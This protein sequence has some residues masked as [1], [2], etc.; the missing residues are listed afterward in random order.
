MNRPL[1]I[2]LIVFLVF[3]T[4]F[5][6]L[7]F[8]LLGTE[9][10]SRW[11]VQQ[12][13]TENTDQAQVVLKVGEV[14][15]TFL[16]QLQLH[17]VQANSAEGQFLAEQIQ[18]VW[19]ASALLRGKL[20]LQ[21]LHIA[22]AEAQ[23]V[24]VESENLEESAKESE[25]ESS[26][27]SSELA[28]PFRVQ[29][30]ELQVER[31]QWRTVTASQPP[32]TIHIEQLKTT[33]QLEPDQ[34]SIR[35][36]MIQSDVVDLRGDATLQPQAPYPFSAELAW[37]KLDGKLFDLPEIQ[38][39]KGQLQASGTTEQYDLQVRGTILENKSS[40]IP[41]TDVQFV[42]I[43]H[44]D[45]MKFELLE[46]QTLSGKIGAVGSMN[47]ATDFS[48]DFAVTAENVDPG[49][50]DSAWAAALGGAFQVA[51]RLDAQDRMRAQLQIE[52][53]HGVFRER[54]IA[55]S[56]G[57]QYK[58]EAFIADALDFRLG[59]NH[60]H[61]NGRAEQELNLDF[62][63]D[64]SDPAAFVPGSSGKVQGSGQLT[65]SRD[66][67]FVFVTLAGN[68][69]H[70]DQTMLERLNLHATWQAG[71]GKLLLS[72][73]NLHQGERWIEKLEGILS[74]T[75]ASHQFVFDAKAGRQS[76]SLFAT[77]VY[78]Q[79][80]GGQQKKQQWQ[81]LVQKINLKAEQLGYWQLRE[82]VA[83]QFE[84][85]SDNTQFSSQELC[86]Q[87]S[88]TNGMKAVKELHKAH[89]CLQGQWEQMD[90][91][92]PIAGQ[93]RG[94]LPDVQK[95]VEQLVPDGMDVLE[96]NQPGVL[97]L[98]LDVSG[99]AQK[100][101]LDGQLAVRKVKL[102]IPET[103][104]ILREIQL[105]LQGTENPEIFSLGGS[106]Q[107]E[108]NEVRELAIIGTLQPVASEGVAVD[109]SLGG[110]NI[111]VIQLPEAKITISPNLKLTGAQPYQLSGEVQVTKAEIVLAELPEQ[112]VKVSKDEIVV[113]QSPTESEASDD[114]LPFLTAAVRIVLPE[115]AVQF[116]GFGLKT[117]LEGTLD[118]VLDETGQQ[119]V[120]GK[121]ELKEG[122]Y[123]A[124]GQNLQVEKGT[125]RFSGVPDNP[126]LELRAVR[127]SHDETVKAW[128]EVQGALNQPQVSVHSEPALSQSEALAYLLT[129]QGLS[130]ADREQG[131][132][133]SNAALSLGLDHSESLLKEIKTEV[134]TRMNI[135]ELRVRKGGVKLGKYLNPDVYVG[136]QQGVF[137]SEAEATLNW[138]L[139][140]KL[141]LETRSDT[142]DQS[143]DL[144][145]QIEYD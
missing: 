67:P 56:G 55:A 54:P 141:K 25:T 29:I 143:F 36:L 93:V 50:L 4:I 35:D 110:E 47:W 89:I 135:D 99:T 52:R 45:K 144:I 97:E 104:T 72:A 90:D 65:G 62:I 127:L 9:S 61:L 85:S 121:I 5:T 73:E 70:Y 123:K 75:P 46:L 26:A 19:N 51:G 136:Y 11:I 142:D 31:A 132:D 17:S 117:G 129:G 103:G 63:L 48:W 40:Y 66:N 82:P 111:Q 86:L 94:Y 114:G 53:L 126:D 27:E 7:W 58:D 2:G 59:K 105:D 109:L 137:K 8:G 37:E 20:H 18:L 14:S 131:I 80:K 38:T 115:E 60:V 68:Q 30:D 33:V 84:N 49:K 41:E 96:F 95:W 57:L 122:H 134:K 16:S 120:H 98:K 118:A 102:L 101:Q 108:G 34:F 76:A 1:R 13:E 74:G 15:G 3:I 133:I 81:G 77:G 39:E 87:Q 83:L 44:P 107:I 24:E 140:D 71:A 79:P 78:K 138:Q 6:L 106:V 23:I 69:L 139:T 125:L 113:G 92:Q 22:D 64:V 100:P 32:E 116:A 10:G 88:K 112:L 145:Y 91:V 119:Q 42:A 130:E 128:L 43:G 21:K 12:A 124:Y 28:L